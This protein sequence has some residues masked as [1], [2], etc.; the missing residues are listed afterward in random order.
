MKTYRERAEA[1]AHH[2][3]VRQDGRIY[4]AGEYI[5]RIYADGTARPKGL[6]RGLVLLTSDPVAVLAWA[7]ADGGTR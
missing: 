7:L 2:L 1:L 4:A 5:G 3:R 6:S